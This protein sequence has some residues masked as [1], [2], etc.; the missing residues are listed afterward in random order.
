LDL[1]LE[2]KQYLNKIYLTECIAEMKKLP[3]ASVDL[4][5]TDPPYNIS[6]KGQIFRDYR[7]GTEH[8]INMDF[9]EWDYEFDPIP[10]LIEAKRLLKAN[11][12]IIVWTSEQLY[13]KYREWFAQNMYPKQ[14]LVWVKQN[15][16]PEFRL[17]KYRQATELMF[18]AMKNKNYKANPNFIFGAQRDMTNVWITPIVGGNERLEHPTQKPLSVCRDIVRNH[19]QEGG[20]VLDPYTGSG[21]IPVACIETNRNFIGM[22][23]DPKYFAMAEKRIKLIQDQ[24]K[25]F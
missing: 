21:T 16:P 20:I 17:V 25:F 19:C 9:G 18:W 22:E 1:D 10:F 7:S 15:P 23:I 8:N 11:G 6:H 14:L 2:I 13:G 3:D 5:F 12:S 4:V 24:G